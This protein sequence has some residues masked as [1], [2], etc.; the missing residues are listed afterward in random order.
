[1]E[2][3]PGQSREV[4]ALH[5]MGG[6]V[7]QGM[8]TGAAY[9]A[10]TG[11]VTYGLT[12]FA[13]SGFQP[14]GSGAA[15][16]IG[17]RLVNSAIV[18]G[19]VGAGYAVVSGDNVLKGAAMGAG[20][21]AAG[22]AANMVIGNGIGYALSGQGPEVRNGAFY[23]SV[24]GQVPF[25]IGGAI[26]GNE[27]WMARPNIVNDQLDYSHT[28]EQH[29]YSHL[30]QQTLLSAA[31]IPLHALSQGLGGLIGSFASGGFW[32]GTHRYNLFER[33]L[34]EIPSY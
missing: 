30:P 29:E 28:V 21:W 13:T 33:S 14:F 11:A 12:S 26:I 32:D 20:Y 9:G 22:E 15:G 4:W 8:L 17:N 18:G 31:Y 6:N 25:T 5:S 27:T 1:V 19:V 3:H 2:R 7:G 34:I 16:I 23:Y 24:N 10:A